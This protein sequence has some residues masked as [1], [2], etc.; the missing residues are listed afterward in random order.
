MSV[1]PPIRD[2]VFNFGGLVLL[3]GIVVVAII[4][5]AVLIAVLHH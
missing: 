5:I 2:N 4:V 1:Q 3:A